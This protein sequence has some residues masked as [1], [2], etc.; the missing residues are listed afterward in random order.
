MDN[1]QREPCVNPAQSE[2]PG[3]PGNS[4]RENREAPL[5]SGSH[6]PDRLEKAMSYTASMHASGELDEQVVPAKRSNQGEPSS[7]ESV[8]GSCS[9]KGN[10]EEAHTRWTQGRARV[11]QG[12]GGVREAARRDKKQKLTALL[13]QV[14]VERLRD[15]YSSRKRN[16]AP[17]VDGAGWEQ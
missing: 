4:M 2:T 15:S 11:S 16:A 10:T 3:T 13:H 12:L 17:G 8:E 5:A 14:T 9:T 1:D 7:A 6:M